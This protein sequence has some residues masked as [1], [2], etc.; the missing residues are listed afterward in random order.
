MSDAFET[1]VLASMQTFAETFGDTHGTIG[2]FAPGRVNLI[3]EHTDYNDG[4]VLPFALPFRTVVV[5]RRLPANSASNKTVIVSTSQSEQVHE[6]TI[7][8]SLAK[9]H[10]PQ[11][12]DYVKGVLFH[13]LQDL[14]QGLAFQAVIASNVPI[15]SGLSSS[16]ALEVAV[17]T[18]VEALCGLRHITGVEKALRCQRAEHTF[19][20]TPC[21]IMDQ[22]ISANGKKGSLLLIDCRSQEYELVPFGGS[23]SGAPVCLV[24]NSNVKHTLSG[25]EYPDRVKQCHGA[26]TLMGIRALRDGSAE[27]LQQ[28]AES[29]SALE[30]KRA[31]HCIGEDARTLA[32]IKALAVG[33]FE[34]VGKHMTASHISLRDDFEVSCKELDILV[35]I[36]LGCEG[37]YGSRM[38][39]GGFGGCTVTLVKREHA[40]ALKDAIQRQYFEKTGLRC[41]CYEA[42]PD[43]GAGLVDL[44]ALPVR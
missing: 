4:F 6:F 36:A 25:S 27:L 1:L 28:H 18:F 7:D 43:E 17:G 26:A 29:L 9:G 35:D 12:A 44:G 13:Y 10:G 14:P 40:G 11:W 21:G 39:G 19:A 42:E 3:G 22:Y 33:D 32:A 34:S 20:D 2:V 15:G 23:N 8:S 5:G 31:R 30:L 38:T 41:E 24:V 37:V 16:A